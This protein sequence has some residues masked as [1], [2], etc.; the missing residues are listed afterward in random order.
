M[1]KKILKFRVTSL[2]F[3]VSFV[4]VLGAALW[5]YFALRTVGGPIILHFSNFSGITQIGD[6]SSLVLFGVGAIVVVVINFFIV[7]ELE[8][9]DKFLG[10]LMAAATLIFALLIFIGFAAIIGVN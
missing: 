2:I 10:K 6:L 9:R 5:S 1:I 8:E 3:L 4:F 7:L